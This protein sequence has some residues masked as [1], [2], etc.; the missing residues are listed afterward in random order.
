MSIVIVMAAHK[1]QSFER[2]L[3]SSYLLFKIH[4]FQVRPSARRNIIFSIT[5]LS[6]LSKAHDLSPAT[7]PMPDTS[8]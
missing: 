3:S 2:Y 6:V 8:M 5:A 1:K 4:T 7:A